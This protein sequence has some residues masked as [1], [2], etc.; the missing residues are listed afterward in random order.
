MLKSLLLFFSLAL[1]SFL[2]TL[3]CLGFGLTFMSTLLTNMAVGG[4]LG[5]VNGSMS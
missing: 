3:V 4:I 1:I 2:V 5:L